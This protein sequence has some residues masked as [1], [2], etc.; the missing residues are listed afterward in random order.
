MSYAKIHGRQSSHTDYQEN[1]SETAHS[2]NIQME[3]YYANDPYQYLSPT[4]YY[5]HFLFLVVQFHEKEV[6]T[7]PKADT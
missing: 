7:S 1:D 4:C 2:L 3:H 6:Q 5:L